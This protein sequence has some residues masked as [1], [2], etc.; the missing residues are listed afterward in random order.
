MLFI[1]FSF[2]FKEQQVKKAN[3]I[4]WAFPRDLS[5]RLTI[6]EISTSEIFRQFSR[7]F[8]F[9][10]SE[11]YQIKIDQNW[12]FEKLYN[13]F[14]GSINKRVSFCSNTVRKNIKGEFSWVGESCSKLGGIYRLLYWGDLYWRQVVPIPWYWSLSTLSDY[15]Y[16][17]CFKLDIS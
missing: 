2:F 15:C 5:C 11:K 16:V 13:W 8:L 14:C 17:I 1:C 3:K 12:K 7:L 10:K 4:L 9:C 6:T